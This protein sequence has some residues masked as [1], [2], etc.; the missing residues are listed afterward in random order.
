MKHKLIVQFQIDNFE[1][2]PIDQIETIE[3]S[4]MK[5][6]RDYVSDLLVDC[7]SGN[8]ICLYSEDVGVSKLIQK[9]NT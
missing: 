5:E 7:G 1:G 3:L 4:S 2:H 9:W 6:A 8:R